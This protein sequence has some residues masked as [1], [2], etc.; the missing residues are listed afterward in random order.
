M[1][2]II[3]PVSLAP[4]SS[5]EMLFVSLVIFVV[6]ASG[7]LILDRLSVLLMWL[8]RKRRAT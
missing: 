6:L 5:G 3:G 7:F 4:L 2:D 1:H 8:W